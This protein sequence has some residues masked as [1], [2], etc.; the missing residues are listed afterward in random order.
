MANQKIKYTGEFDV[1]NILSGLKQIASQLK[2]VSANPAIFSNVDKDFEKISKMII[3]IKSQIAQGFSDPKS[4]NTFAKSMNSLYSSLNYV[5]TE[6]KEISQSPSFKIKGV[7]DAEENI[8]KLE[9]DLESFSKK[10][11][12]DLEIAFKGFGFLSTD[13]KAIANQIK[14][15][16]T[17]KNKLKEIT[18][19]RQKDLE[20]AKEQANIN[21]PKAQSK[22]GT[23]LLSPLK[24]KDIGGTGGKQ[25][26]QEAAASLI[27]EAVVSKMKD[28]LNGTVKIEDAWDE[29]VKKAKELG[30][31]LNNQ[32]AIQNKLK[33]AYDNMGAA[34]HDANKEIEDYE[35][36]LAEM[37]AIGSDG[38]YIPSGDANTLI[39]DFINL[40]ERTQEA[41]NNITNLTQRINELN[42]NGAV[43][44][45]S[46]NFEETAQNIRQ[47]REETEENIQKTEELT[48]SQN[49]LNESFERA[50]DAIKTFL[51]LGTAISGLRNVVQ[52]TFND[53]KELDAAF[54]SIAM[55]TDYSVEQMWESY[56]SYAEM[57]NRLGQST[58]DVIASSAL[59]Y[60]QGLDTVEALELT[61]STMKL[62]TLAGSDFETATSQMT[63][64]LRGFHMEMTEGERIT[65]VYSELAAK[66]AA[67]VDG[68]AYAMSK[69]ASIASSAGMEFETTSAFLTQM[70]ETTQEAPENIG[71]AMKTIEYYGCL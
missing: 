69:T 23:V 13:A 60:Q 14:D 25:G 32:E 31:T 46:D 7:S 1:S 41:E 10:A 24:A 12:T 55:V 61:E 54:A 27:N 16:E 45:L 8:K 59:F 3:D 30:V 49:R 2:N 44:E 40:Q 63:A 71:T 33:N 57:A 19:Q 68:I 51:S 52:Q 58:K 65:D 64:A 6:L 37:G 21:I 48:E 18:E 47:S 5:Q 50:K 26:D 22:A 29:I 9:K 4:I 35:K 67:D 28:V 15:A 43:S 17:L 39:N 66:A 11:K 36:K 20:R 42:S 34:I 56:D 38:S 53:I 70:I 62:A